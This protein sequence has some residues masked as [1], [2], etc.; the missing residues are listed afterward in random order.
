[1]LRVPPEQHILKFLMTAAGNKTAADDFGSMF[2]QPLK[3]WR[4]FSSAERTDAYLG[5]LA[6]QTPSVHAAA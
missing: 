6:A 2:D 3:A 5:R 1:M 4:V